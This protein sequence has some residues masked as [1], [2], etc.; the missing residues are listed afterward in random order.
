MSSKG[1]GEV[2]SYDEAEFKWIPGD[3]E[4]RSI[5][6]SAT[7]YGT[8]PDYSILHRFNDIENDGDA[9]YGYYIHDGRPKYFKATNREYDDVEISDL[10]TFDCLWLS[11][12]EF[13]TLR[14]LNDYDRKFVT[15]SFGVEIKSK[16]AYKDFHAYR[17][18]QFDDN[19]EEIM[20]EPPRGHGFRFLA[21]Q[22]TP[23]W[24]QELNIEVTFASDCPVDA[25]L[26]LIPTRFQQVKKPMRISFTGPSLEFLRMLAIYP[27][28]DQVVLNLGGGQ[29]LTDQELNAALSGLQQPVHL[30]VP[31]RLW[32]LRT[33]QKRFT[34]N[35]AVTSI[36]VS[37][38]D[39]PERRPSANIIK[40]IAAN[41]SVTSLTIEFKGMFIDHWDSEEPKWISALLA[42]AVFKGSSS[43]Q[44]L[45]LKSRFAYGTFHSPVLKKQQHA[46]DR[47]T[48][49]LD[50]LSLDAHRLSSFHLTFAHGRQPPIKSTR[51][52]DTRFSPAL[53][54]NYFL[55]Q[56]RRCP[57]L[58]LSGLAV[59]SINQGVLYSKASNL[60]P[61][62]LSV[63]SV[64]VIFSILRSSMYTK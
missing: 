18:L 35:P 3:A 38:W 30:E 58:I 27:I 54:L 31:E 4:S 51:S 41:Q 57:A 64:G 40:G 29:V 16:G 15:E 49:H 23:Y 61:W 11:A 43:I 62:N 19:G 6:D 21:L 44:S 8:L 14:L 52:W 10:E 45:V 13:L 56:G 25:A 37:S 39:M 60:V 2:D 63:S 32:N 48:M 9:S 1:S 50:S 28:H 7:S 17:L 24:D 55:R 53:V 20:R 42:R 34:A 22:L 46:F 59:R 47:L 36:T 12:S 5:I 26:S 33:K